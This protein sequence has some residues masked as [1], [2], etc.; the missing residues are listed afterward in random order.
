MR[1]HNRLTTV[2]VHADDAGVRGDVPGDL[3]HGALSR[4]SEADVEEL[5]DAGLGGE[6]PDDPAQE[7]PVP[8]DSLAHSGEQRE[9]LLAA[10]RSA[11]SCL[12]WNNKYQCRS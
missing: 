9:D 5:G 3:V 1:V 7:A 11:S 4:Q 12:Y 10:T 2:V 8:L 6:E